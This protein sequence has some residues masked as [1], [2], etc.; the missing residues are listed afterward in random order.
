MSKLTA[1]RPVY[2]M[3][4]RHRACGAS[5]NAYLFYFHSQQAWVIASG[6]PTPV[7]VAGQVL[8]AVKSTALV[9]EAVEVSARSGGG[10][11]S[12]PTQPLAASPVG[13]L[14]G[15]RRAYLA[16]WMSKPASGLGRLAVL[17]GSTLAIECTH[18][19]LHRNPR[20]THTGFTVSRAGDRSAPRRGREHGQK[21]LCPCGYRPYANPHISNCCQGACPP[22][23]EWLTYTHICTLDPKDKALDQCQSHFPSS[24]AERA[25]GCGSV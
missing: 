2:R 3:Y 14:S 5:A 8:M 13:R 4:N 15:H 17:E 6:L 18:D 24:R 7:G 1:G 19:K 10:F 22:L 16:Q 23:H 20:R 21:L 12:P 11:A 25:A 9:P